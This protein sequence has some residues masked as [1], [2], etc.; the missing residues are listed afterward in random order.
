MMASTAPCK[1][2]SRAG[3]IRA[4]A[5][6]AMASRPLAL[7]LLLA[8]AALAPPRGA[9][10]DGGG[11]RKGRLTHYG[12]DG[13]ATIDQGSCQFGALQ[14]GS[15]TG[16]DIGA[17]SDSDPEYSGSCGRCYEVQCVNEDVTDGYGETLGRTGSCKDESAAVVI[18]IT[19]T[20]P[21]NY[22]G[23]YYSNKQR[24]CCGDAPHIVRADVSYHAFDKLASQSLG[25]IAGRWRRVP[26]PAGAPDKPPCNNWASC[27]NT[28]NG[29]GGSGGAP[30]S[31]SPAPS[32]DGSG[33]GGDGSSGDNGSG[34]NG[35]SDGGSGGGGDNGSGGSDE[36]AAAWGRRRALLAAAA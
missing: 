30:A 2:C 11:W 25:V 33:G 19:D 21:C 1:R 22:P 31:L 36:Q 32:G 34:D 13:G 4:A 12:N 16:L 10:A 27:F 23:N 26:C 7:L 20:C 9:A 8:A 14:A 28:D 18:T 35:G 15:G 17:L 5:A 3:A 24:W 6:S 29:G